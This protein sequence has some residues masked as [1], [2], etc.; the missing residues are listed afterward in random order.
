MKAKVKFV[1]PIIILLL[2][3]NFVFAGTKGKIAGAVTDAESGKPLPAANVIIEGTPLGAAANK[4][5]HYVILNVPPG[6]YKV[7]ASMMGYAKVTVTEARVSIDQ[8]TTIDFKMKPT[9]L[10][11][12]EVIVVAKR[13]IVQQDVSASTA[14]IEASQIEA[15]PVVQKV[16][17]VIGLQAGILGMSIRGGGED[18]TAFMVDGVT[19]RDERTNQPYTAVSLSSIKSVQIQTGGFN[20]EY[21]NIRSGLVNVVTREGS[22]NRYSGRV[23][24]RYSPPVPKHFGPSGYDP[25]SYWNRPF[26]DDAV[27]W[28][29]TE[30]GEPY[31]DLNSNGVWDP[32]EPLTDYN[33]DGTLTIWDEYTQK[34]YPRF[35]GWIAVSERTLQDDDPNN[36]LTPEA[37]QQVY[38]WQHRKQGDIKRPDYNIDAGFGGPVPFISKSLGDLRFFLAHRQEQNMYLIPLARD[39]YN[40]NMSQ[41]KLTSNITSNIKLGISGLYGE[42][43]AVNDN[44]VGLPGYFYSTEGIADELSMRSYITGIM[45]GYD[46]WCPTHIYRHMVSARVSHTLNPR[47]FYEINLERVG[48]LY[49]T[50]PNPLRDTTKI[51]STIT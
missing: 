37:A 4:E 38:N 25:Y 28:T 50:S 33:G 43:H 21:G 24:L 30:N 18:E 20:A 39:G 9:I 2:S 1:L 7:K 5:G 16:A 49:H 35:E 26:L 3:A 46:Y 40:D 45:Y 51:I 12:E 11:G 14:N 29:G 36:D 42:I 41:L 34:Q 32:D 10:T 31:D 17:D 23:T 22:R 27:C 44:N 19:L 6:I 8:T 47:T 15:L 48:N 13:P